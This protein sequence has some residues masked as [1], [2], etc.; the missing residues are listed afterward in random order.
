MATADLLPS[1]YLLF[2]SVLRLQ[3]AESILLT[4]GVTQT[5]L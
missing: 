4:H 2:T 1:Q 3:H 5:R